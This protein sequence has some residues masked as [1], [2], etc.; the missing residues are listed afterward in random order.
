MPN[1]KCRL[2]V[3]FCVVYSVE[4]FP[5]TV[6]LVV[7]HQLQSIDRCELYFQAMLKVTLKLMT[8]C[9]WVRMRVREWARPLMTHLPSA[10]MC[11]FSTASSF[12]TVRT[13]TEL[14]VLL[15][16]NKIHHFVCCHLIFYYRCG[17]YSTGFM[18]MRH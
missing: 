7:K 15:S 17:I 10:N 2:V 11:R 8:M 9:M 5:L 1:Q 12:Y 14:T 16:K 18:F 3:L 13:P 4:I 6:Q